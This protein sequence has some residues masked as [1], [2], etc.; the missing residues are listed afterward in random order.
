[1][2]W[3]YALR[4]TLNPNDLECVKFPS[5]GNVHLTPPTPPP[6]NK[7][8]NKNKNKDKEHGATTVVP[9]AGSQ[10]PT[11][12]PVPF[13]LRVDGPYGS[14][15]EEVSDFKHIMLVGAGIGVTPFASIIRNLVLK[16][17]A[18]KSTNKRNNKKQSMVVHFYW[19]CRSKEEFLSFRD[20]MKVQIADRKMVHFNLYL[21]GE[22]EVTD[23]NFQ[24]ELNQY[25]K[26]SSLYT[27]RPNWKRIFAE[28]R[29]KN[30]SAGVEK[31]IGVFLCGPRPIA[32]QLQKCCRQYSD[33][34]T[35]KKEEN[36]MS[37]KRTYFSFHQ[38]TF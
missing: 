29:R 37:T 12:E 22:T 14:A 9:I 19:L 26:W 2:D 36:D 6:R 10:N 27:G 13:S 4:K 11:A 7:N 16:S 28:M 24:R 18:Q 32:V 38:E 33:D 31:D 3:C 20:L 25:K 23:K 21:S 17:Q 8:K 34:R 1:M 35:T 15:A 5:H 30:T